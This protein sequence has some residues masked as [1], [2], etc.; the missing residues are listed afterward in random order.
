MAT[1]DETADRETI[2]TDCIAKIKQGGV[3]GRLEELRRSI[4]RAETGKDEAAIRTATQEYQA[5]LK[6]SRDLKKGE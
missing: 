4:L 2:L 6:R 3:T 5:L 1:L